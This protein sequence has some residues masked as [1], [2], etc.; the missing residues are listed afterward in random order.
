MIKQ[1]INSIKEIFIRR[2]F[3]QYDFFCGSNTIDECWMIIKEIFNGTNIVRGNYIEKYEE[4]AA[5]VMGAKYAYS[6]VTG[7]HALYSILKSLDIGEGDEVILQAFTCVVVSNSIIYCGAMPI[8]CDIDSKTYNMDIKQIESHITK[9]TKTIIIQHTFGKP[10]DIGQVKRIIGKKNIAIIEDCAHSVGITKLQGDAGFYSSDHTKVISTSTGGMA[11]TNDD[12]LAVKISNNRRN[13]LS[14]FRILQII[15]TF[16]IEVTITHP[17]IYWLLKPLRHFLDKIRIF[18]FFRDENKE[19]K[20]KNC[21]LRLSNIQSFIGI[22][23]LNNL[24]ANLRHRKSI[25]GKEPLLRLSM[26]KQAIS[27]FNNINKYIV[28]GKWFNSVIFGCKDFDRVKYIKGSCPNAEY[29]SKYIINF[30][31]H[32]RVQKGKL[33]RIIFSL[34]RGIK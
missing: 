32:Q 30:P 9:R 27:K 18:Y 19:E 33:N 6:F 8:Y 25:V 22:N 26:L 34:L 11:F 24:Q 2:H 23:Q 21:P 1:I 10:A 15:F 7:R 14:Y 13:H 16:I 17:R 31:T 4:L 20:P 5:K 12:E 29:I 3:Y 28:I